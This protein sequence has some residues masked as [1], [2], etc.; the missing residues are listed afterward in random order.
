M[1]LTDRQKAILFGVI[2]MFVR[3]GRPVSSA[4]LQK[5]LM[6]N[7]STATIR[8]ELYTLEQLG[9]IHKGYSSSG[10]LP[11]EAGLRFYGEEVLRRAMQ[12][13]AIHRSPKRTHRPIASQEEFVTQAVRSL[14]AEA[15]AIAFVAYPP[16]EMDRIAHFQATLWEHRILVLTLLFQSDWVH[17][18]SVRLS[19]GFAPDLMFEEI[20]ERI[21][22]AISG[23]LL[24]DIREELLA[25][26][27]CGTPSAEPLAHL[28]F[29]FITSHQWQERIRV[30]EP[31]M[32]EF[33]DHP[34]KELLYPVRVVLSD[35]RPLVRALRRVQSFPEIVW[36]SDLRPH[37]I[38]KC[39][40]IL[41]HYETPTLPGYI[42][43]AGPERLDYGRVLQVLQEYSGRLSAAASSV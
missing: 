17:S 3:D 31:P 6:Q 33:S 40:F 15:R 36:G 1:T 28:I 22:K 30:K 8:G 9:L 35:P 29:R 34:D 11:T 23:L 12:E 43:I 18:R 4:C 41:T 27:L 2:E 25:Q 7:I 13:A 42:G 26:A 5:E 24:R 14:A 19:S 16:P 21:S 38:P 10:R 32:N 20:S 39:V 37:P